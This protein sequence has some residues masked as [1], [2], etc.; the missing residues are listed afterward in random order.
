MAVL[1]IERTYG[2]RFSDLDHRYIDIKPDVHT[3]R[4]LYRLG[5]ALA[6][7]ETQ[8]INAAK[9]LNPDYPGE[10]DAPLWLIGRNW[11]VPGTPRCEECP[12]VNVC[13]QTY[14]G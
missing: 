5:V 13:P 6:Q 14:G 4:V 1:L 3:M 11:C 12:L 8:A 2:I 10:I 9:R 7:N